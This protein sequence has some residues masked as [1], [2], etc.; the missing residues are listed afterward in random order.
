MDASFQM[1]IVVCEFAVPALY[2]LIKNFITLLKIV[3]FAF[4][5]LPISFKI[6]ISSSN[7]EIY[8][9]LEGREGWRFSTMKTKE[10]E[11]VAESKIV[12]NWHVFVS[13][14]G[15]ET[16]EKAEKYSHSGYCSST[17]TYL[18]IKVSAT[19]M[20]FEKPLAGGGTHGVI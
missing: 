16:E 20:N 2:Q 13:I 6:L 7:R 19:K 9:R 12:P 18:K 3:I 8:K 4:L 17:I 5:Y 15:R 14:F 11:L 1:I 10:V